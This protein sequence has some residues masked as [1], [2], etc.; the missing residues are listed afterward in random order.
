MIY[1]P[2]NGDAVFLD[3]SK[4]SE[5]T[6][7]ANVV[8]EFNE[9]STISGGSY[10]TGIASSVQF[11]NATIGY[12]NRN[13]H[14]SGSNETFGDQRVEFWVRTLDQSGS[15]MSGVG[16]PGIGN[17]NR[18][19]EPAGI[20]EIYASSHLVGGT[21]YAQP[22]G[23]TATLFGT[24]VIP[25]I[26]AV[27][28]S[29]FNASFG[30]QAIKNIR[31]VIS[32]QGFA[33]E[34]AE[35]ALRWGW[36][37]AYNSRQYITQEFDG[38]SGLVPPPWPIWMDIQNR[39]RVVGTI[40]RDTSKFG[41]VS[42]AN[43]ARVIRPSPIPAPTTDPFYKAGQV[44]Y[45]IRTLPMEGIAPPYIPGWAVA[46]NNARVLT[47][48]GKAAALYGNASIIN[49]RR[50]YG[51][52]GAGDT[53]AI[54][55]PMVSFRIRSLTFDGRYAISPPD[56][57]LP[58]VK[59]H[60]RYIDGI[61]FDTSKIGW[62][63]LA[64]HRNLITPHWSTAG[65]VGMPSVRNNTPEVNTFGHDSAAFG[66][67]SIRTQWRNIAASGDNATL[68]GATDIAYRTKTLVVNGMQVGAI[69]SGL[70]VT[71]ASSPPY[72]LQYI[73][74]DSDIEFRQN[75]IRPPEN[76]VPSPIMNQQVVYL[77]GFD[78][79]KYGTA[80]V[81]GNSI[82]IT[83][84][85]YE[86]GVGEPRVSMKKREIVVAPFLDN[87]VF[88][89][90]NPRISPHT[91]W[92]TVEAPYQAV[93]NHP[94]G[95]LHYVDGWGRVPGAIFGEVTV[96][97]QHRDIVAQSAGIQTGYGTPSVIN[98]TGYVSPRGLSSL[99]FGWHSIPG[100]QT[101][102]Q[103]TSVASSVFGVHSLISQFPDGRQYVNASG[104]ASATFGPDSHIDLL[105]RN[106]APAGMDSLA[107][108]ASGVGDNPY[109]WQRL[110]IGHPMPTLPVGADT[111]LFGTQWVSHWVR[112][113][114]PQGYDAF[115]CEYDLQAFD[116]RMRVT[117]T[118]AAKPVQTVHPVGLDTLA[119][120]VSNVR[121][122]ARYIRPDGNSD[123]YRKGA[124]S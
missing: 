83:S 58:D 120:A 64:I 31:Q 27:Y 109:T 113:V 93:T 90:G 32:P 62:A 46:Y 80:I 77:A 45:R 30:L 124:P 63:E 115:V 15:D 36:A 5:D 84:G 2:P 82:R 123:Q 111:S 79:A 40:G 97:L 37:L 105:N 56:I 73:V 54:G 59:L 33:A 61:G 17:K 106:I 114:Q 8:L 38:E 67:A 24:R 9:A 110:H 10:P 47:Q 1:I 23:F 107:M 55:T 52:V 57:R 14:P 74:L 75:G 65:F 89:P 78:A 91:I 85:I 72:S 122:G 34:G 100:P 116:K 117:R 108:G 26:Q 92:A 87:Q 13:V 11:G 95:Y 41:Y 71:Q 6:N 20:L 70:A 50:Y 4:L 118:A 7:G 42:A 81:S 19:I 16:V 21:Q 103:Y 68:F 112:D 69:G 86:L 96:T 51:Y 48:Q 22:T 53:S 49:T 43:N 29:G 60:T 39:N 88:Q 44:A 12:R 102:R 119:F 66:G 104:F 98:R 25:E 101:V 121:F 18:V 76:Q 3:F 28:P 94:G 35:P 99:R